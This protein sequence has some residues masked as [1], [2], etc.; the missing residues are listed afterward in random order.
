MHSNVQRGTKSKHKMRKQNQNCGLEHFALRVSVRAHVQ[1]CE[2]QVVQGRSLAI[3][4]AHRLRACGLK[5]SRVSGGF[6]EPELGLLAQG[7]QGPWLQ[8]KTH[9]KGTSSSDSAILKLSPK[10]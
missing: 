3:Y 5:L 9:G 1:V 4:I 10:W 8:S 7:A 6:G 2:R